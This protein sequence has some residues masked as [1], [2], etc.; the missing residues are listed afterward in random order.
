METLARKLCGETFTLAEEAKRSLDIHPTWTPE[1]QF[2]QAH[3]LYESTVSG[4]AGGLAERVRAYRLTF[5]FPQ[6]P[7]NV[8]KEV[9]ELAFAEARKPT[10]ALIALP[11]EE[12]IEMQY[13]L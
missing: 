12:T 13:F 8:L 5:A 11:A 3:A 1:A 4:G 9:I 6:E 7:S 10:H 2:E